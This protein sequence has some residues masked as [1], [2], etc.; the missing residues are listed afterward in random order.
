MLNSTLKT[1]LLWTGLFVVVILLWKTFQEGRVKSH[2]ID[3]SEFLQS[4]SDGRVK[5]VVVRG[6]KLQGAFRQGGAYTEGEAVLDSA[7]RLSRHGQGVARLRG[8]DPCRGAEGRDPAHDPHQLGAVD[9]DRGALAGLHA[10]DAGGRQPR[11]VVRQEQGEAAQCDRQESHVQGRR[12]DR[13]G[14]GRT[15]G[16]RRFPEGAGEVPEA[17]R[18]D[19]Q[20]RP[21]DGPS[22]H[23]QDPARPRHRRRGQ[24]PVLFDLRIGFRR[25]VR[26]CRRLAGARPVRA[27]QEERALHRVHRRDRRRRSPPWGGPGR[28][29]RRARADAQPA[30]RRDGRL[31]DQRGRDPHRRHQPSRR[32]RPGAPAA[33]ALRSSNRGR[34]SGHQRP[35]RDPPGPHQVDPAR[36]GSRSRDHRAR[37]AGLRRRRPGQPG[38]RGGARRGAAQ[39]EEGGARRLRVRQGQGL[40]GGRAQ[41]AGH[42]RR[43]EAASPRTTKRGTRWWAS[44]CPAPTRCTR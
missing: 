9:R 37:H 8:A 38:Q 15:L 21:L 1:L 31:R 5:E 41:D 4:V 22:G 3:F 44:S 13:G 2:E 42:D 25:D 30:A 32:P 17:R 14:E 12:R 33:R 11:P 7:A 10:A 26:R 39:Q 27:G 16:N 6:S 23:R 24:R 43:R 40:D 36:R 19:P 35:A 29:S 28:R 18:Q 34:S 20:G